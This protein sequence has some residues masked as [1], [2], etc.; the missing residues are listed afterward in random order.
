M[1]GHRLEAGDG[2]P[3]VVHVKTFAIDKNC[4]ALVRGFH[5]YSDRNSG[6]EVEATREFFRSPV[7]LARVQDK[8]SLIPARVDV[9]NDVAVVVLE[10]QGWATSIR[11]DVGH[12]YRHANTKV[13]Y[14]DFPVSCHRKLST[15][16]QIQGTGDEMRIKRQTAK[17]PLYNFY[18]VTFVC[19]R[20]VYTS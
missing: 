14:P 9:K 11:S 2:H 8:G 20:L 7:T 4:Q 1:P 6:A 3:M 10:I 16:S 12:L 18:Y 17:R 5:S 15:D 13:V 19:F